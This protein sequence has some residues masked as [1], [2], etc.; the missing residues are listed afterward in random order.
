M[1]AGFFTLL[2]LFEA[3]SSL[4]TSAALPS[5]VLLLLLLPTLLPLCASLALFLLFSQLCLHLNDALESHV[6]LSLS[7]PVSGSLKS[8]PI[9]PSLV[10]HLLSSYPPKSTMDKDIQSVFLARDT[11]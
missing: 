3:Y 8:L 10:P 2:G 11:D 5:S 6:L 9:S 1:M 4:N 7:L